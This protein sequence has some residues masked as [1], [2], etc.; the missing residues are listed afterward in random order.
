MD[1]NSISFSVFCERYDQSEFVFLP[2][3]M[4]AA[5]DIF[6]NLIESCLKVTMTKFMGFLERYTDL[7]QNP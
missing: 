5:Q 7:E 2:T 1:H 4:A 3:R 6:M